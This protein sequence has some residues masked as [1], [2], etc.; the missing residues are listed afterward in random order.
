[1]TQCCAQTCRRTLQS[2]VNVPRRG[3]ISSSKELGGRDARIPFLISASYPYPIFYYG[4]ITPRV[5]KLLQ[6]MS[7]SVTF[8]DSQCMHTCMILNTHYSF[9]ILRASESANDL[10]W[11]Q[12]TGLMGIVFTD[13]RWL[14][15]HEFA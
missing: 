5:K 8:S 2:E 14:K 12:L 10:L 11:L 4:T 9:R 6:V 1:M 3:V 13:H 7:V 15:R